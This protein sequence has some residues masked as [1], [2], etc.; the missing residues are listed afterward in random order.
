MT[1]AERAQ[2]TWQ[3]LIGAAHN[4]QTLTYDILEDMTG[5]FSAGFG[6][7]LDRIAAYCSRKGLPPLTVLVVGKNTGRP[8]TGYKSPTGDEAADRESVYA[9]RWYRLSPPQVSDFEAEAS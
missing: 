7:I 9:E 8:G 1:G 4:R 2:Q 6:P 5:M 3:V